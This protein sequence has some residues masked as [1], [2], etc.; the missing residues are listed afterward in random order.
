M[1]D[2]AVPQWKI[3]RNKKISAKLFGYPDE[4][5]ERTGTGI[6]EYMAVDKT[7][8]GIISNKIESTPTHPLAKYL[9]TISITSMKMEE[10][11]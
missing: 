3:D 10:C 5:G 1:T 7:R 2:N 4:Y 8:A 9:P 6:G 11:K